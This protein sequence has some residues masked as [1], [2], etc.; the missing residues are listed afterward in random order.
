MYCLYNRLYNLF[1]NLFYVPDFMQPLSAVVTATTKTEAPTEMETHPAKHMTQSNSQSQIQSYDVLIVILLVLIGILIFV[2]VGAM[3]YAK[4]CRDPARYGYYHNAPHNLPEQGLGYDSTSRHKQAET[5][6]IETPSQAKPD[7]RHSDGAKA[8]DPPGKRG[9]QFNP[10]D[11]GKQDSCAENT[12]TSQ[13]DLNSSSQEEHGKEPLHTSNELTD[14][15]DTGA[16]TWSRQNTL[17]SNRSEA[18]SHNHQ[19]VEP[20]NQNAEHT[21]NIETVY[22]IQP[23]TPPGQQPMSFRL[24][25]SYVDVDNHGNETEV[26]PE[27]KVDRPADNTGEEAPLLDEHQDEEVTGQTNL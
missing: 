13:K 6:F 23:K 1:L 4:M 9:K 26:V 17:K 18:S 12:I 14:R 5:S 24:E 2:V 20:D 7:S 22:S 8:L 25:K 19:H 16:S 3:I 27:V 10:P 11:R 21:L 15:E